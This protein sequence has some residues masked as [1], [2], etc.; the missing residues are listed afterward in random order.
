MSRQYSILMIISNHYFR[1]FIMSVSEFDCGDLQKSLMEKG[2]TGSVD[3]LKVLL[4]KTENNY[5]VG[6]FKKEIKNI[7]YDMPKS[8]YDAFLY[9]KVKTPVEF[10]AVE[11]Q[12]L[13]DLINAK[14][15]TYLV[16]CLVAD[17]ENHDGCTCLFLS[18]DSV[19]V[20]F[21]IHWS[22]RL[23]IT[24]SRNGKVEHTESIMLEK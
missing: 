5:M 6:A 4:Q 7:V 24:V 16:D 13:L 8:I 22:T 3:D 18:N 2:W 14:I 9:K 11:H 17:Y 19:H 23:T 20:S 12:A 21:D 15:D 1:R 10:D